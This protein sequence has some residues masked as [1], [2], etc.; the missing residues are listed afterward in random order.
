MKKDLSPQLKKWKERLDNAR[1]AYADEKNKMRSNYGYYKGKREIEGAKKD[2]TN[3]RNI[4]YEIIETQ[5]D[6]SIPM[7]K[8]RAIHA[9]DDDLA[10]K[11]EHLLENKVK[12]C[13]LSVLNDVMERN[14]PVFGADF[15]H[16]QWDTS[17]GLHCEVGDLR[18]TEVHPKK[19]IPQPGVTELDN[20][21]YFFIQEL[22]TK[23]TVKR[24]Y[25]IDVSE[26]ENDAADLKGDI[27]DAATNKDLVTVNTAYYRNDKGGIGIYVW[28]DT[29]ELL[30]MEE[31]QSRYLERCAKCGAVMQNGE[32][33]DCH[34]KKSKKAPE[35]YEEM[36]DAIEIE[37]DFKTRQTVEPF[38]EVPEMDENG[39]IM[40]AVPLMGENGPMM[41]EMGNPIMTSI[42]RV[43][44]K[45]KKIP[46]YK[47]NLWPIVMRRNI[48]ENDKFLGVSEVD[49]TK[50]AQDT[51]KKA[52][53]KINE[54]LFKGGSFVTLPD[55]K[56]IETT[57]EELK[58]V[59]VKNPQEAQLIN[60][61]NVQPDVSNDITYMNMN[62]EFAKSATGITD[63][64]QGKFNS[65]EVSGTARQYAINQAAGRFESRRMLKNEAFAKLYELMFK[66]WLAYSDQTT[67][68]TSTDANGESEHDTLDR[69]EFLK[70]DKAGEFYWND[71]FIFET[72]P[73]ST[74]MA[75]REAMWNQT[76]MKLQSG[77]FGPLGDLD[78]LH[79]YW[80]FMKASGY[81]NAG[82]ALDIVN[83]R[84]AEQQEMMQQNQEVPNAMPPM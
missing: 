22:Y 26:A 28:C 74:L 2:A 24:M 37:T 47:P 56:K 20:M 53:T 61:L 58:I 50:D 34:G 42:P 15:F 49:I 46:Y 18:I 52:Q 13:R 76:D 32:C 59:R 80:T 6:P 84:Q 81:P 10:R 79:T 25:K 54:K 71:E 67:E 40:D 27:K 68:I 5:V 43:T 23:K 78:T 77:A 45:K 39:P 17:K 75:N 57:D 3:V 9:A 8:V 16:V 19:L 73:T 31:Y 29:I 4:V 66:Y 38:E 1:D 62:Y 33:P 41:D 64:Y 11:I 60:V 30:D 72:D 82:M 48:T 55:G 70:L 14:T 63:A 7:P 51:I 35:E 44:K 69:H 83:K 12:T 65:A 21:D 36:I